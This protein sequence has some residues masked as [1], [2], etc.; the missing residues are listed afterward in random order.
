LSYTAITETDIN[1]LPLV[2][3]GKV[4]D[5]YAVG[6]DHLLMIATDRVSAFDVVMPQPL[7]GKGELLTK[8]ALFWFQHIGQ[9]VPN[10]L[11]DELTLAEVLP[12][13]AE[14]QQA[15][16]RSMIVKKLDALP[17]EAVVRGYLIGSG[18]LDYQRSGSVCGIELPHNLRLAEQLPEPIFTPATKAAVGDHDENIPYAQ[19]ETI[20][21]VE[22]AREV[23]DISTRIYELAANHAR[24]R[25]II[26]ADTK[27]EFGV[28]KHGTL[29]LMD[30]VL[31]PDSSRF[32]NAA[33]YR[34]GENPESFDKQFVRD[35]LE[36]LDWDKTAPGPLLPSEIH[37]KTLARYEQAYRTLTT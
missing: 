4:R 25:G 32:W 6:E 12:D 21:G 26:I 14:R 11:S 10:H 30:E 35:Y 17:V 16:G 13:P 7:P 20:V 34:A 19:M 28:D 36:T 1:S 18:W 9:L 2:H 31:T 15:E 27:F 8:L 23:R 29:T 3:R 24:E 33:T 22:R 37:E 5:I